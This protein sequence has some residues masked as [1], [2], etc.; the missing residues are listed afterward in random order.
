[1]FIGRNVFQAPDPGRMMATLRR[2]IHD[3][4]DVDSALDALG[5]QPERAHEKR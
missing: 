5:E 1:M 4:L 3:E 2:V